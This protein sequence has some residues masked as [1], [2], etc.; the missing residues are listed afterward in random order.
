MKKP[1]PSLPTVS[2]RK[3]YISS[4]DDLAIERRKAHKLTQYRREYWQGYTPVLRIKGLAI[5]AIFIT[6]QT[7]VDLE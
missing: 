5:P 2:G 4:P 1:A 3:L 6:K 7:L